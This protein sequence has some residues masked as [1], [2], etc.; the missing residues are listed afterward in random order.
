MNGASEAA[1]LLAE[2]WPLG[3]VEASRRRA[4]SLS[5]ALCHQP[6]AAGTRDI[7]LSF[8]GAWLPGLRGGRRCHY[9]FLCVFGF[10]PY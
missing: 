3:G 2:R 4:K 8:F 10:D 5:P 9:S 6:E 7:P 1:I